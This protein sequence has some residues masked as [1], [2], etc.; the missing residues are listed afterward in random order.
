MPRVYS[1]EPSTFLTLVKDPKNPSKRK[2]VWRTARSYYVEG[3]RRQCVGQGATATASLQNF[4]VLWNR[5]Q[6]ELGLLPASELLPGARKQPR[7]D[8]RTFGVVLDEWWAIRKTA[9]KA[10]GTINGD[11]NNITNHIRPEYGNKVLSTITES[12][13]REFVNVTLPAKG[14]GGSVIRRVF[15][16]TRL[17]F[18]HALR[19]GY[20]TDDPC[21][22]MDAP[23]YEPVVRNSENSKRTWMP[24]R[25]LERLKGT[26]EEGY[27]VMAFLGLRQSE[28][29]G[30][31]WNSFENLNNKRKTAFVAV[32]RQLE[33]YKVREAWESPTG[34]AE[35]DL[36]V[37]RVM[38]TKNG[39]RTF[40]LSEEV[41][42]AILLWKKQQDEWKKSQT[43]VKSDDPAIADLV[44]TNPDGTPIRQ[45]ADNKQWHKLFA[46][47][48]AESV[49]AGRK[50]W[51]E[52][53]GHDMR[54]I[55]ATILAKEG[56]PPRH[57]TK[58]L[59]HG[60]EAMT[61]Y[62][63]HLDARDTI[64]S[65]GALTA[66]MFPKEMKTLTDT[67]AVAIAREEQAKHSGTTRKQAVEDAGEVEPVEEVEEV[68]EKPTV[69]E[70]L[71]IIEELRG[72]QAVGNGTGT[73]TT[74]VE[75]DTGTIVLE[76]E[77]AGAAL[78]R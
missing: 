5:K 77:P 60:T 73:A 15:L 38:K 3:K 19:R 69:E 24:E 49:K 48:S 72:R 74:P 27:W 41:R 1:S 20:I 28:R 44:F 18:T 23:V 37:K 76:V 10:E 39:E 50:P 6:V 8:G 30:L 13:L 66:A 40:A 35:W 63:T 22:W 58:I 32:D 45:V 59:G 26:P 71:A 75:A 11:L 53:R 12:D 17:V 25:M 51:P 68:E 31:G 56:V 29:L 46:R 65:V 70:L 78:P 36:R 9:G 62:Y 64:E 57:A 47:F 4:E 54:H 52:V 16:T 67:E 42:S 43:W 34:K 55:A 14:L 33:R 7:S 61:S 2:R 21:K